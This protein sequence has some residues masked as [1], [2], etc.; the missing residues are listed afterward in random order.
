MIPGTVESLRDPHAQ[1]GTGGLCA[2]C[3]KHRSCGTATYEDPPVCEVWR[4]DINRD[5]GLA[6]L[7]ARRFQIRIFG[8]L[9]DDVLTTLV[10]DD[11]VDAY[12]YPINWADTD[13]IFIF[14]IN[15]L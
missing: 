10:M 15:L 2:G 13:Y 7:Q 4:H 14:I 12:T 9:L 8:Q 3:G 1:A 6:L 11:D 5:T